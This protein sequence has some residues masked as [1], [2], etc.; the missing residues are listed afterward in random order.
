MWMKFGLVLTISLS[1]ALGVGCARTVA[2]YRLPFRVEGGNF[3]GTDE[4]PSERRPTAA[5]RH[6]N[7]ALYRLLP[8]WRAPR[9]AENFPVD[10]TLRNHTVSPVRTGRRKTTDDDGTKSN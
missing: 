3:F 2:G 5:P 8:I 9:V 7:S 10:A 6:F 1:A 4:R